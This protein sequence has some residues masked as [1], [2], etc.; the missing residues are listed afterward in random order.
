[1]TRRLRGVLVLR[2][3][4]RLRGVLREADFVP[5]QAAARTTV[6]RGRKCLHSHPAERAADIRFRP[7][8][9]HRG[10]PDLLLPGLFP[11]DRLG[12][13]GQRPA[14]W[15]PP[16]CTRTCPVSTYSAIHLCRTRST[17]RHLQT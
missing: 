2:I 10:P 13:H 4:R 12:H 11:A 14:E 15:G 7:P 9:R 1:M 17:S 6:D 3:A 5:A 16:Y 8:D